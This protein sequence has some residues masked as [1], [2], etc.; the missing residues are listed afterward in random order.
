MFFTDTASSFIAHQIILS[1]TV[2]L[3]Y[4][5]S[6]TDQPSIPPWGCDNRERTGSGR[7]TTPVIFRNGHTNRN[8]PFPCFDEYPTIADVLDPAKVSW[9]LYVNDYPYGNEF[10]GNVWNGFDAIKKVRYGPDWHNI[11]TPETSVFP[12][13]KN[14]SLP[15]VS[16]VIP[17]LYNSDHPGS[18]CSNGPHWVTSVINAIG[19]SQYWKDTAVIVLWDDWGGWYDPVPPPQTN[20]TSL[21]FR[22][23]MFVVSPYVKTHDVSHTQY[24][25]GSILKF[26]EETFGLRSLNTTDKT[27]TSIADMFDFT[28]SPTPYKTEPLPRV[29]RNCLSHPASMRTVI[30]RNHGAPD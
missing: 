3:N 21:G 1:G 29:D 6:L 13:L 19:T 24:E 10:S 26:I 14:G 5:E 12:D 23:P 20:Y 16:W 28:Q 8:G 15:S 22:I 4:R 27:A 18:G 30:E 17:T 7:T 11:V 25:F 2:G 9:R